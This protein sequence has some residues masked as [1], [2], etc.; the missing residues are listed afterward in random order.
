MIKDF[1]V[2]ENPFAHEIKRTGVEIKV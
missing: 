1:A 2:E